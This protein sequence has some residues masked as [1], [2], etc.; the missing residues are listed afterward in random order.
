MTRFVLPALLTVLVFPSLD[1][2]ITSVGTNTVNNETSLTSISLDDG[3]VVAAADMIGI[4]VFHFR[5]LSP[6]VGLFFAGDP[7]SAP[8]GNARTSLLQDF[9]LNTGYLQIGSGNGLSNGIPLEDTPGIA[10]LFATP[11]INGPGDDIVLFEEQ[12]TGNLMGNPMAVSRLD[13]GELHLALDSIYQVAVPLPLS[14]TVTLQSALDLSDFENSSIDEDRPAISTYRALG[15]SFDLS[16]LGYAPGES[17]PGL[18]LSDITSQGTDLADPVFIAG[19]PVVP[20]PASAMLCLLGATACL[21]RSA[22]RA[23][24]R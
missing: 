12:P 18:F 7:A 21:R 23:V 6:S 15:L 11:V 13:G 24:S 2:A 17:V 16:S 9:L 22:L 1:A 5:S 20:E 4:T 3:R 19:L 8:F 10:F 14:R